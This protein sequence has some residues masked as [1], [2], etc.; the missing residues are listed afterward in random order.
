MKRSCLI[1]GIFTTL[2]MY[3]IWGQDYRTVT[4]PHRIILNLTENPS[5]SI[6]VTWRTIDEVQS[7]Q[8]QIVIATNWT[9][10]EQIAKSV[11]SKTDQIILD[12][13]QT[14][15]HHSAILNN[16]VPNTLYAYRVG[17]DSDW[18]EWNQFKTASDK[19]TP[20]DFVYFGDMQHDIK[21]FGSRLFREA[22]K[23]TTTAEFWLS[24]GDLTD[25]AELDEQ[26]EEVFDAFG[27]IPRTIPF[28]LTTGNHEYPDIV[29]NGIEKEIRAKLWNTHITQPSNIIEGLEETVFSFVYQGVR[30]VILNSNEKLTEQAEWLDNL[31]SNNSC[32]WIIVALHRPLYS[33]GKN[34]DQRSSRNAF[35]EIFDKYNVDLVLQGHDHVYS[36][37]KKLRA[38]QVV[39]EGEPGTIYVVSQCGSDAYKIGSPY[40][41]LAEILS[42]EVQLFQV[43]SVDENKI[44]FKAFT[45]TNSLHDSFELVK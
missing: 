39:A 31:L 23:K 27:F 15:Y 8:V 32:K 38:D 18:S 41:S 17:N 1:C 9:E 2:V 20:F 14:V 45:A 22:Y 43:I 37:S 19:N 24:T 3:N 12:N 33:M 36:R 25:K 10:F 40:T 42:N 35:L 16:L 13:G 7:S 30:F 21:K 4:E 34:R 6:A 11:P 44:S 29:I 28:V 26:W 5:S